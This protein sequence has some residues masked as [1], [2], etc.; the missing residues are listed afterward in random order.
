LI[1][2]EMNGRAKPMRKNFGND[3]D[4]GIEET[5]RPKFVDYRSTFFLCNGGNQDIVK[6]PKI[7]NSIVKLPD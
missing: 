2:K 4:Y 6:I 7:H 1:N 3:L 5:N